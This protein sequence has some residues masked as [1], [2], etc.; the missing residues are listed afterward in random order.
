MTYTIMHVEAVS[1]WI[2][3]VWEEKKKHQLADR[4]AG[5]LV[6]CD[7]TWQKIT[8]DARKV[9]EVTKLP[10]V[11]YN[12]EKRK[13]E[14]RWKRKKKV[15]EHREEEEE[16]EDHQVLEFYKECTPLLIAA[17]NGII[18]V[19]HWYVKE[20]PDS[21]SHITK[22]GENI[23]FMAVKHRQEEILEW[24]EDQPELPIL[25]VQV[26]L[27]NRSAL[28]QAARMDYYRGSSI[29][30]AAFQ[31]QQELQWYDV[32]TRIVT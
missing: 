7:Y 24:L 32:S 8:Y 2:E 14:L 28:H 31:L 9:K 13:E 3:S 20:H 30:G 23:L 10:L 21:I 19:I 29:P 6:K 26:N 25:A 18:E 1:K 5:Y 16:E 22:E 27:Q 11:L 4:L 15:T 17:S 12:V